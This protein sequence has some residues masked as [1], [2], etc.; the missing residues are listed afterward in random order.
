MDS[1]EAIE[2]F[3]SKINKKYSPKKA[4]IARDVL[5]KAIPQEG[6][7]EWAWKEYN[8]NQQPYRILPY[9]FKAVLDSYG[10]K[11]LD[12]ETDIRVYVFE[13]IGDEW[14]HHWAYKRP[15]NSEDINATDWKIEE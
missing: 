6:S 3:Y 9:G 15:L 10:E 12:G 11:G 2:Y 7:F 13:K 1:Q 14:S 4:V 8:D 5:I